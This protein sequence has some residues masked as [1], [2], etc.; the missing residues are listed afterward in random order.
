VESLAFIYLIRCLSICSLNIA[1][2]PPVLVLDHKMFSNNTKTLKMRFP[3]FAISCSFFL[4]ASIG[5]LFAQKVSLNADAITNPTTFPSSATLIQNKNNVNSGL[6]SYSHFKSW[7]NPVLLA[8]VSRW[9]YPPIWQTSTDAFPLGGQNTATGTGALTS[10]TT[11]LDNTADGYAAL[12][13]NSTGSYNTGV[14]YFALQNN[15]SGGSQTAVG[16]EALEYSNG[17]ANVALG[18]SS[19]QFNQTGNNNTAVGSAALSQSVLESGSVGVGYNALFSSNSS[20]G[21]NTAIGESALVSNT[22]GSD[23]AANGEFALS[24]N[25]S[26]NKNAALGATALSSNTTGDRNTAVGYNANVSSSGITNSTAIGA[27]STASTSNS[28]VIG[29]S[30]ITSIGG[31]ANWS[32]FSDGRFK[33]N[34]QQNVPGLV[35]I[36]KLNPVTYTLDITGIENKLHEN[37]R[38]ATSKN[39]RPVYNYLNDPEVKQSMQDKSSVSYSGF[40]A[41]DV[42]KAADSI[43]YHFSGV[44]KPKDI[45]Q[46]F[47]GLRYG[48]FVVPLVKAVQELSKNNEVANSRIDSLQQQINELRSIL[49]TRVQPASLSVLGASLDQNIPNPTSNSTTIAYSLPQGTHSA[50]LQITDMSGK[51]LEIISLSGIG[52]NTI[53]LDTSALSTG[54]YCYSL[55]IDGQLAGTKKMLSAR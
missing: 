52:R 39:P 3:N 40:V 12:S 13:G 35:F 53:T 9:N 34:I 46:S 21:Y 16:S 30:A 47:Y 23:N 55:L 2:H 42:E 6:Q 37:Q 43:G 45:N 49:L 31:Y 14:G 19:L 29:S 44:D 4:M 26:G 27:N 5:Q 1:N 24:S 7:K 50:Q 33:K 28:V 36:N 41:Q 25:T 15:I 18:S 22:S 8:S 32:N 11:G 51:V 17:S 48:D 54:T 38:S 20:I 10:L